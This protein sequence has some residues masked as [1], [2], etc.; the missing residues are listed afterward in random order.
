MSSCKS[1]RVSSTEEISSVLQQQKHTSSCFVHK[2]I[3]EQ[4]TDNTHVCESL[5]DRDP[6]SRLRSA[7][8]VNFVST[9]TGVFHQQVATRVSLPHE[10]LG[11]SHKS[12]HQ[13]CIHL[14]HIKI[15]TVT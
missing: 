4:L 12:R 6:S 8:T 14:A 13:F 3:G 1:T 10:L 7:A 15:Y 2:H 5:G 11:S 9:Y